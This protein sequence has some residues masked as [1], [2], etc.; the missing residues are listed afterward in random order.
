MI[1]K[2]DVHYCNFCGKSQ[3]EAEAMIAGPDGVDICDSCVDIAADIIKLKR[4]GE[5]KK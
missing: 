3:H 2:Q 1:K 4:Q 5:D